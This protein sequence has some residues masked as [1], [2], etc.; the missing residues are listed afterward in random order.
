VKNILSKSRDKDYIIIDA[1]VLFDC[2]LDLFCDYIILIDAS[3][4]RRGAF[5][6]NEGF[7]DDN[8]ELRIKGQHIKINKEKVTFIINNDGSKRNLL[9]KVE[10]VLKDI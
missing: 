1:A 6:K 7:S 4:K 9:E 2:K 5:L 3:D 10:R 8:T